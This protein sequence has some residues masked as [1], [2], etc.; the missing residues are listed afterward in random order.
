[1]KLHLEN[2]GKQFQHEWIYRNVNLSA[3]SGDT[4]AILGTNGTGK[5]TLLQLISGSLPPTEGKISYSINNI[6]VALENVYQHISISAHYVDLLEDYTLEELI[7]FHSKF[8]PLMNTY[9]IQK[10]MEVIELP[11]SNNKQLKYFSSGM[12]QRVKHALAVLSNTSIL[13]ID[14]PSTNLDEN[15]IE[16]FRNLVTG[17]L[18]NRITII[19]SNYIQK[20]FS[21]CKT[22]VELKEFQIKN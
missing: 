9:S 15:S 10:V 22:I 3:I 2:I 20:E 1:M 4:L 14:E 19:F 17:N 11:K 5:S 13:L 6:P 12:K 7:K 18:E 21:F 16:W 8:K